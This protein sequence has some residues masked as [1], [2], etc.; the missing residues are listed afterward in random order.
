M[1]QVKKNLYNKWN[2][3]CLDK[4]EQKIEETP[5]Q[6]VAEVKE[7]VKEQPKV[8]EESKV[9]DKNIETQSS[10][11]KEEDVLKFIGNRYGKEIK[12]LDELNQQRRG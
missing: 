6:E 11:L 9:E 5:K 2:K 3:N 4:H 7:E 1:C 10:E 12:S 8:E